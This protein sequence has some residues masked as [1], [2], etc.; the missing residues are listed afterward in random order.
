MSTELLLT[1]QQ[2]IQRWLVQGLDYDDVLPFTGFRS[3]YAL[4]EAYLE[5]QENWRAVNRDMDMTAG[6]M[7]REDDIREVWDTFGDYL[8]ENLYPAEYDEEVQRL[9]PLIK[10]RQQAQRVAAS[11]NFGRR[12]QCS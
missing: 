4:Y 9:I 2:A 11:K 12:R 3:L 1:P 8:R 10:K 6:D 7:E 5:D